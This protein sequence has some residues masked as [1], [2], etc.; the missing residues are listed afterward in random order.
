MSRLVLTAELL[1]RLRSNL[2]KGDKEA[3]AVLFG[4]TVEVAGRLAR[5]VVR[6]SI[7]PPSSSYAIRTSVRVQLR[8]EFV[9]LAG[10]RTRLSGESVI[11]VH[12]HPLPY[13][14][15]S[16]SDDAGEEALA[17]FLQQ[18]A[19]KRGTPRCYLHPRRVSPVNL[20]KRG[21]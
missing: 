3:C 8:P 13:N 7:E 5:I 1:S 20:A 2:L 21:R 19:P 12:T 15:F 17:A 11:F 18:R 14:E 6:E 9:A 16:E 4:R 10:Q